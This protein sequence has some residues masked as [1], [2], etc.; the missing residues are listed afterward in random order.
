MGTEIDSTVFTAEDRERFSEALAHE[1]DTLKQLVEQENY[2]SRPPVGGFEIEAWLCDEQMKPAP[3][4]HRFLDRFESD[5]ATMELARFNFELNNTPHPLTA[6]AFKDF[7]AQMRRTC[8]IASKTADMMGLRALS[9]GILP[10]V[11]PAD[12]C[13]ENMS[14]MK[15]YEALNAEIF[16]ARK[17]RSVLLDIATNREHLKLR[18]DSVMLEA[19]A[20]SFQV[21][22]QV[23]YSQAHHY[24]NASILLSAA[25]VALAANA[26][27][28][29]GKTLWHDTRI[30]LFEQAIETGEGVQRVSFGSDFAQEGLLECFEENLHAYDVL[31]PSLFDETDEPFKHL[32]LHNGTVWRWNRPL[33]GFDD[34]G[35][36]HFR[37]EHRVMS[38]GPTL[39]DSL[40][41][42]AFYYGTATRIAAEL[43]KGRIPCDFETARENF[44][45]AA[46]DGLD[47]HIQ[48]E[49]RSLR[50]SSLIL[51]RLL[52]DAVKGLHMLGIGEDDIV[53]YTAIIE[54][55][56]VSGQ[57]GSC[58]QRR[59]LEKYGRDFHALC[60]A[61]WRHQQ[62]GEPVHTWR[63]E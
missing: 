59:Y 18:H 8:K 54:A 51:E 25:T 31:L 44:Y 42:A 20:T 3:E 39:V 23:P 21:H 26:P 37:I 11:T 9:I 52:P 50:L 14:Q 28:L 43:S 33:I 29:F 61:Y 48:W 60:E 57:N 40:A 15:R 36:L 5:L 56:V 24:Y 35:T 34:D 27:F 41:N 2:S 6:D 4:N 63:I 47:A 13:L 49:G 22:T 7:A 10:T 62:Q 45:T 55:R 12:F 46:R 19:A 30:P 38:A 58:W 32:R 16:R 1:T 17:G 53:R